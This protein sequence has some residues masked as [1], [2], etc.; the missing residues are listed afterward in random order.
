MFIV[1]GEAL[2]WTARRL[3][4]LSGSF[5]YEYETQALPDEDRANFLEEFKWLQEGLHELELMSAYDQAERI[6]E[7]LSREGV[8][9]SQVKALIPDLQGRTQDALKRSL[10]F[11]IEERNIRYYKDEFLFGKAVADQLPSSILDIEEAGKCMAVGR[12]TACVFH[13]MRVMEI[14]V[15]AFGEGLGIL[16]KI[17][18]AQPSWGEL[19]RLTN[20]EIQAQ[21]K[22]GDP[23]W[24]P[25]KRGFFENVQADLMTV[26]NACR[27]TTMHVEN[28][29]DEERAEDIFNAVKAFMRH[30]AKHLDESGQF[31][32]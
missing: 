17:K 19:L 28:S 29:Y 32:P 25:D 26:K 4:E 14:G 15:K 9:Y 3:E 13:L 12:H 5:N 8:T 23:A 18:S 22:S 30:L 11:F 10:M 27:N 6:V 16:A 24:T 7:A 1:H 21:N 20:E 2:Y 31:T